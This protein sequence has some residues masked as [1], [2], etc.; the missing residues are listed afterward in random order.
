MS[1]RSLLPASLPGQPAQPSETLCAL[2]SKLGG[3]VTQTQP[4]PCPPSNPPSPPLGG[5]RVDMASIS[6]VSVLLSKERIIIPGQAA[7]ATNL[8][9]IIVERVE[10]KKS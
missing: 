9:E 4:W 1:S 3:H 5:V 6:L 8:R 10:R 2:S 7:S